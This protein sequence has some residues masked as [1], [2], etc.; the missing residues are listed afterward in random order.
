MESTLLPY[1]LYSFGIAALLH[2]YFLYPI[3]LLLLNRIFVYKKD[4]KVSH[5]HPIEISPTV[6]IVIAVYNEEVV[7]GDKIQ[8]C[9]DLD[10]PSERLKILIASDG[11]N[12]DTNDIV[13]KLMIRYSW[14]DT[15]K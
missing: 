15:I 2:T 13:R 12:D 9:L 10:Y 8:N 11:S 1:I 7:I 4:K 6:T 3:I 14:L 5:S